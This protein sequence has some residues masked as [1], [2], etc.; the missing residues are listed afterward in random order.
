MPDNVLPFEVPNKPRIKLGETL[1]DQRKIA[2]V[3]YRVVK[4]KQVTHGMIKTLMLICSYANRAGI[5]WVGQKRLAEDAGISQQA[6]SRQVVK[7]TKLGYLEVI[8]K[9]KP[10][11]WMTTW[12][13]IYDPEITAADAMAN[14]SNREDNR[15]PGIIKDEEERL[16]EQVNQEGVDRI[17]K[18]ILES[19]TK[20]QKL[21]KKEYQMPKD[22]E[23]ITVKKMKAEIAKNKIK[24]QHAEVVQHVQHMPVDNSQTIQHLEVVDPT[25]PEGC[26]EHGFNNKDNIYK[27][28]INNKELKQFSKADVDLQ[29][30]SLHAAC[31][32]EGIEPT[33][34]ALVD[35]IVY[36]MQIKAKANAI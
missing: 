15:P 9:G 22:K 32:S 35:G 2:I 36:M 29:F 30:E 4:D 19:I 21:T 18:M 8:R 16:H 26:I 13:V 28:V 27:I 1:P 12:R 31:L 24:V 34:Q 33:E 7:L 20:A 10:G 14:T 23:T 17:Q 6:I 11:E 3:P 25:T 5:T